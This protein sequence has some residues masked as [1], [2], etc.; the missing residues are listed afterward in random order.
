MEKYKLVFYYYK[1][2]KLKLENK[3]SGFLGSKWF[4]IEKFKSFLLWIFKRS[5]LMELYLM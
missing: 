2:L 1:F 5:Y 3:G 4:M